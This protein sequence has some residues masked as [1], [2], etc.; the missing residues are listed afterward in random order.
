MTLKRKQYSEAVKIKVI[1]RNIY[2]IHSSLYLKNKTKQNNTSDL[3]SQLRMN[4]H[5]CVQGILTSNT[6]WN[7]T[8]A[9]NKGYFFSIFPTL[10]CQ[11]KSI[12][13]PKGL[14]III[15]FCLK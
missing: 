6:A 5:L 4:K 13:N 7:S 11:D 2:Y 3:R 1:K 10:N 9:G 15:R 8:L 14:K 12:R